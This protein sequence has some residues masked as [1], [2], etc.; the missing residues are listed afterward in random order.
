VA[1]SKN[2]ALLAAVVGG[3]M[4]GA[5]GRFNGELATRAHSALEAAAGLPAR[6][7]AIAR[8]RRGPVS[9]WW[10]VGGLGGAFFVAL[11]A[12]AVPR[13]GVAVVTVVLVAGTTVGALLS[14]HLGLGPSGHHAPTVWRLAGVALVVVAVAVSA[15]GAPRG[16]LT[17]WLVILLFVAGAA[18][19]VQQAFNG[20]INRVSGDA[21]VASV[22]S[23]L[24]GTTA[25]IV[26]V[27][28][29]GQLHVTSLP[30]APWLYLGGPLG[31]VYILIGASVVRVLGVLRL[32]LAVVAGQ[33]LVAV[34]LDAWWP[35]PGTSLRATTVI[36]AVITVAGV[37]LSGRGRNGGAD[38]ADSSREPVTR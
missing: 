16:S 2:A 20:Q 31:A 13:V 26:V 23:F 17:V 7:A 33:L 37:W 12:H 32:V 29:S 10:Y 21:V 25:L 36:G 18:T 4:I 27:A 38:P 6:R 19:A 15:V 30:T 35:E 14:D 9:W 8:L 1:V 11:A 34:A 5:Q 24:G 3:A 28:A 22:V